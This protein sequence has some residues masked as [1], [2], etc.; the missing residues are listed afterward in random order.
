[1]TAIPSHPQALPSDLAS[2]DWLAARAERT[3]NLSALDCGDVH[4]SFAEYDQRVDASAAALRAA[5]V[6]PGDRVALLAGQRPELRPGG[7]C[8]PACWRD[9]GAA[10]SSA[11]RA[12]AARTD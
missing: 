4:W 6:Q 5:G 8:R 2:H 9:A 3:P 10:Q 7:A 12:G 11:D 1:M